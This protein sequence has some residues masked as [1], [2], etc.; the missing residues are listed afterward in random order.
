MTHHHPNP[1]SSCDELAEAVSMTPRA[2][3]DQPCDV[4][5][6]GVEAPN[7]GDLKYQGFQQQ[8]L[9][10]K[11]TL[12]ESGCVTNAMANQDET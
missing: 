4:E 9:D 10:W 3:D 1:I 7:T 12:G 5:A 6:W 2:G 8:I 11:Y